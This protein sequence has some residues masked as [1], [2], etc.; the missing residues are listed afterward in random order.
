[1]N[2][3]MGR[4]WNEGIARVR[5]NFQVLTILGGIFF[6]VPSVLLFIAMPDAMGAMMSPDMDPQ[7]MEQIMAGLGAGFFL[8]YLLIVLASFVGYAA[9]IALLGDSRRVSVGEAIVTGIKVLLPLLALLVIFAIGYFVIALVVGLVFGLLIA[10]VGTVSGGIAA[11]LTF[12]M[13][14]AILLAV[15]WVLTRFSM[16]LPVLALEGSLNPFNAL[17][18]S[19][20]LTQSVHLRLFLFYVLLTVA[21]LVIAL[22]AFMIMGTLVAAMGTPSALGF[23]NGVIGAFVAMVFSGV[24]VG[25]YL[26][27]A[28]PS[29]GT[30]TDAFE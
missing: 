20:K 10:A 1:M 6:F 4:A 13:V 29:A 9:M 15:L 24:V 16:T 26:Q 14:I 12:V 17:G 5:A 30:I 7:N 3:D 23:L 11:A 19:W 22:V 28:G 2:F 25:I 18:R 8:M 21:Y 27:L